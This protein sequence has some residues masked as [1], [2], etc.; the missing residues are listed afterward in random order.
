MVEFGERLGMAEGILKE[1]SRGPV[2]RTELEKRVFRSKDIS[3]SCF[4]SLFAFLVV[5]GDIEKVNSDR[6]APFR[7]TEKGKAFLAWRAKP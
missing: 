4:S 7:L 2:R 6:T 1:L 3:F 5:D